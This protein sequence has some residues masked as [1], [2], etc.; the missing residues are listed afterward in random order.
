MPNA[1]SAEQE[2]AFN[3][4]NSQPR[5][6]KQQAI[7]PKILPACPGKQQVSQPKILPACSEKHENRFMA[8]I[9][10]AQEGDGNPD[11]ADAND[12]DLSIK[13]LIIMMKEATGNL[14]KQNTSGA[15]LRIREEVLQQLKQITKHMERIEK[16]CNERS[17][18]EQPA[19]TDQGRLE[20]IEKRRMEI[21]KA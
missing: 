18:M 19:K 11:K 2:T 14:A 5:T 21:E 12:I 17:S 7:L 16:Q 13:D 9:M 3:P 15:P 10:A 6:P 8:K 20:S 1:C 4:T